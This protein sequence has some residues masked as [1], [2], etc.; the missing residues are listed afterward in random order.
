MRET[1][2][3]MGPPLTNASSANQLE[4]SR[5]HG[6]DIR[7]RVRINAE[8]GILLSS[9]QNESPLLLR[10][11]ER[12]GTNKRAHG[13]TGGDIAIGDCSD[14]SRRQECERRQESNVAYD[15]LFAN[16][17]LIERLNAPSDKIVHPGAG[18]GDRGEQ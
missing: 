1:Q 17:D 15:L 6:G 12:Q 5:A 13:S 4:G 8:V 11:I 18:L 14:D 10:P 9:V 16:G 7:T 3:L 2:F